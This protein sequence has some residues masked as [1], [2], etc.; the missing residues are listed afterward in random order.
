MKNR[1]EKS[2]AAQIRALVIDDD[3]DLSQIMIDSLREEGITAWAVRPTPSSP[4]E[5]VVATAAL[6]QPHVILVDIVMPVNTAKLVKALRASPELA[7]SVLIGCSGHDALA[8]SRNRQRSS[9][10]AA[11]RRPS[12]PRPSSLAK[13]RRPFSLVLSALVV[14]Y[15]APAR[16]TPAERN[17]TSRSSTL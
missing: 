14:F 12:C 2:A 5:S 6:F 3:A 8:E 7:G 11:T 16:G 4:A 17:G 10:R 13:I 1:S 15:L 9:R